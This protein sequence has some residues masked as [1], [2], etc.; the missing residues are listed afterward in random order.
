MLQPN[1]SNSNKCWIATT[2]TT[3]EQH[4]SDIF[5]N[6]NTFTSIARCPSVT[7]SISMC[8]VVAVLSRH[9]FMPPMQRMSR[10]DGAGAQRGKVAAAYAER[11]AIITD[12]T[13]REFDSKIETADGG[14]AGA[15][16]EM[17][18]N[19]KLVFS[20]DED[21]VGGL[22]SRRAGSG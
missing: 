11:S 13:L 21:A 7:I 4:V 1:D 6:T 19:T 15:V 9:R 18:Y 8:T 10:P 2:T 14:W 3:T 5:N 20:D 16:S 17:D 12:K 22:T